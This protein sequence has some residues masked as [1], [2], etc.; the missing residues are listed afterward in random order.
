MTNILCIE[1]ATEVCS[2]AVSIDG[3]LSA[4]V[5]T[6][7]PNSHSEKLTIFIEKVIADAKISLKQLDA[8][9]VSMGPGSYTGLRIGVATAK[10]FCYGLNI[11]LIAIPTLQAISWGAKQ[12]A[13]TDTQFIVPMIDA[14]RMEVFF[15]QYTMDLESVEETKPLIIDD[16]YKAKLDPSTHYLFC[17]N[18]AN[19]CEQIMHDFSNVK[20]SNTLSSAANMVELAQQKF[21]TNQFEDLAYFEPLYVKEY[22]A[23]QSYVKGLR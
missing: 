17:G 4:V 20:I 8:V 5:E 23:A 6:V 1:T 14:R 16:E 21:V 10:G 12:F 22:I 15:A 13:D 18:G 3:K 2:V 11:P 19:K 7:D 9:A